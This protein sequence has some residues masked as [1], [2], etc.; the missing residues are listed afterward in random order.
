MGDADDN[1]RL[2]RLAIQRL[3][4]ARQRLKVAQEEEAKALQDISRLK[5]TLRRKRNREEERATQ[6]PTNNLS[7][8]R[9]AVMGTSRKKFDLWQDHD[10]ALRQSIAAKN[11]Q[12]GT[13]T[14]MECSWL[15]LNEVAIPAS[16]ETI[17]EASRKKGILQTAGLT[18]H[19]SVCAQLNVGIKEKE[20]AFAFTK[21]GCRFYLRRRQAE[22]YANCLITPE[23]QQLGMCLLADRYKYIP[24][25]CEHRFLR[26][27]ESSLGPQSGLGL[28]VLPG[29]ALPRGTI[30]CE[31]KGHTSSAADDDDDT[32][33]PYSVTAGDTK[34][35]GMSEEG[36]ITCLAAV[37]NDAGPAR[38]NAEC[39]EFD[40]FLGRIFL[41]A[42][43]NIGPGEEVFVE[44]GTRYWGIEKY[45][46]EGTALTTAAAGTEPDTTMVL[47]PH[48]LRWMPRRLS[49]LHQDFAMCRD[50]LTERPTKCLDSLPKNEFTTGKYGRS[51]VD[52]FDDLTYHF[53]H[54]RE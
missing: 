23:Y 47:C 27:G 28:F 10:E 19:A 45:P 51:L 34:I 54:D 16:A 43:K 39:I 17:V 41:V 40:I 20:E 3:S 22:M 49:R 5:S 29:R 4:E 52:S 6:I 37:A 11:E 2:L 12:G 1:K 31:Y 18:P 15:I 32:L 48:C 35:N 42:T 33:E 36:D 46:A 38:K 30:F 13:L 8:A 25:P 24:S 21:L 7:C 44:Y 53:T 14:F 26:W 50:P 9:R